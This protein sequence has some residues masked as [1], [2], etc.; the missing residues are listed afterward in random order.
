MVLAGYLRVVA[1]PVAR[2]FKT[3]IGAKTSWFRA[4]S[5]TWV[6]RSLVEKLVVMGSDRMLV[7]CKMLIIPVHWVRA[8]IQ[9]KGVIG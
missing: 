5:S 7:L 9:P 6:V 4:F 1:A 8:H 2:V 3:A